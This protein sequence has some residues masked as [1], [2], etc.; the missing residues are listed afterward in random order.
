VQLLQQA[1]SKA[2]DNAEIQFHYAQALAQSGD[3]T[4]ARG[5]LQRLLA[6]GA[7]FSQAESARALLKR[8]QQ[9]TK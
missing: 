8:L 4:R 5:E 3:A 1:Q 7:S 6:S 9:T 2:P